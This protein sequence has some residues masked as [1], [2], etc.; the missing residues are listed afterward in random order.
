[1][2]LLAAH[3]AVVFMPA[4]ATSPLVPV[5]RL[6]DLCLLATLLVLAHAAGARVL[7]ALELATGPVEGA[8]YA[9][10]L[11]LGMGSYAALALGLLGLYRPPV[12]LALVLGSAVLLRR[13]LLATAGCLARSAGQL[14]GRWRQVA[15]DVPVWDVALLAVLVA[16][17]TGSIFDVPLTWDFLTGHLEAPL[18]DLTDRRVPELLDINWSKPELIAELLYRFGLAAGCAS[19]AA[20]IGVAGP[21]RGV[22][23]STLVLLALLGATYGVAFL[24]AL[25]PPH[26]WDPLTYHL[27][28]PQRFLLTGRIEPLPGIDFATLPF[29]AQLLYGVGLAFGSE[30][31]GQLLH[32]TFAGLT[33]AALWAL[34]A[35]RFDRPTAWLAVAVFAAMPQVP[36]WAQ[37][38]NIDLAVACFLFLAV[39][40]ALRATSDERRATSDDEAEVAEAALRRRRWLALAGIFAGLALG[41]KYQAAFGVAPLGLLVFADGWW[42]RRSVEGPGGAGRALRAAVGGAAVFGGVAAL[43]AAPWY[44]KN[45]L[46][47]G[48]PVWPLVFGGRG[49]DART[50]D[51][52]TYWM[53]GMALAPRDLAGYLQL[54]LQM[55]TRGDFEARPAVILSPL[56]LLLPALVLLP[57]RREVLYLLAVSAGFAAGWAQGFQ[58]LRYL[59]PICAP[60]S[61]ATAYIL[62]TAWARSWLRPLVVT[63]LVGS[64]LLTQVVVGLIVDGDGPIGVVFGRESRDT[65]MQLN[66]GYRTLS[67]LAELIRPGEKALF[68]HEAQLYYFP[69]WADVRTDHLGVNLIVLTEAHPDPAAALAA[70]QAQG[71]DYLLVNEGSIRFW[72][73]FDPEDRLD[74]AM[75]VYW[76]F[77]P[78]LENLHWVGE[79]GRTDAVLF[80]V[81]RPLGAA[82]P[83]ER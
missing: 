30:V 4:N 15:L 40:A 27:A 73:R 20:L 23:L 76:G 1:M 3:R 65:Y 19:L 44:L 57:R 36:L 37:V 53:R 9:T 68:V 66:A 6:F 62:R 81:P 18:A 8:T 39:A 10:A 70:L 82:E 58:E 71:I 41:S 21:R 46:F 35:R 59:L 72:R 47:L 74:R 60:L 11:G 32:F 79:G 38:A 63:G 75:Q 28:A 17:V 52:F 22:K 45:W 2:L 13:D 31:F 34:A 49:F 14:R 7:R 24:G 43:I 54:P 48:N 64:A 50:F 51:V 69:P 5:A 83:R 61:L 12:L 77:N 16:L 55:Y 78:W 56:F 25:T 33:A 29:T 67:R 26:H 80:R 42:R